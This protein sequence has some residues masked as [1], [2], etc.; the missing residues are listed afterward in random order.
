MCNR[1]A[2]SPSWE[3]IERGLEIQEAWKLGNLDVW[4]NGGLEEEQQRTY[5]PILGAYRKRFGNP[6][7]LETRKPR[8]L[9][10]RRC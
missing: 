5:D 4:R 10:A 7:G 2:M 6:G 3:L 9:E 8:G 1:A